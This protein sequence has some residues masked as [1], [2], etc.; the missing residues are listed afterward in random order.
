MSMPYYVPPEQLMKDRAD[1]ARKGIARGRTLVA[2]Q[3]QDGIAIIS[4]NPSTTLHKISEIYDRIAF[5]GVGKYNEFD[6]LRVAG[7]RAADLKGYQFSRQ[8]VDARSLTNQY[9]QILSQMF[10]EA[11]KP[12]EVELLVAEIGAD[13]TSDRLFHVLYDGTVIDEHNYC[14]LGGDSES[15]ATRLSSAFKP[16][17]ALNE[18]LKIATSV[19]AGPDRKL[20]HE[21]LEVAI[22]ER[23]GRRR[24]FKRI[25]DAEVQALLD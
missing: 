4:E 12:M 25:T 11:P 16:D 17:L 20:S 13:K 23:N 6:Q 5:A 18:A 24:C 7:V 21:D 3:Y 22:L 14:V 1:Y 15:V 2:L 19:L 8:D 9:A 10:S